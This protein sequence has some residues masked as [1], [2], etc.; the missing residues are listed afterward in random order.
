MVYYKASSTVPSL[1]PNIKA[2][3]KRLGFKAADVDNAFFNKKILTNLVSTTGISRL[4]K[5]SWARLQPLLVPDITAAT[6]I[7]V[8]RL[9]YQR[10][11][12]VRN[13]YKDYFISSPP[14][15]WAYLPPYPAAV[16]QFDSVLRLMNAP[17]DHDDSLVEKDVLKLL[18]QEVDNWTTSTMEQLASFLPSSSSCAVEGTTSPDL[19]ALNLATSVFQC[20]CSAND[21]IRAGGSLIGWDGVVPHMGCRELEQSWEKK[22]HFSRRGHDAAKVLVRLL[23]LDPATTKVWEMDALDKRF[24]CLICPPTRVGRTA[25]TWQD[26]VYHHIERSK[27]NPHDALLLGVVGP[28]AEARVKSR[29]KP[30]PDIW[31]HNWM[32]NHCPDL[33]HLVKPR[34]AVI[35]H[36]KDIHDIS[37]PINNLDYVYFLGD[38]TYRRPISINDREFLCLRCASTKCRLY[39]WMGIQA[40]LKDS[41]G[42]S[43]SV[44]HEDW[45]KINTI[46]RTESTS[47]EQKE[48]Q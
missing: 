3:F 8:R 43:V 10:T 15:T 2:R 20:P 16:M 12:F 47:G 40:H 35:D 11:D 45:K 25:Y 7:R 18:P 38:R 41:H 42:L 39:N 29:E 26:A 48:V 1:L 44:E 17:P 13:G 27:Y 28:E 32:C 46:L 21:G 14:A 34:A 4:G 30:E 23:G 6:Q 5:R 22:L 9:H 24:V 33:E 37:R 19:S 31:Q 36:I